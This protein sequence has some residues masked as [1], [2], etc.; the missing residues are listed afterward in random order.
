M[1]YISKQKNT[2]VNNERNVFTLY[3]IKKRTQL[4]KEIIKNDILLLRE[5]LKLIS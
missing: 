2:P 3:G 1:I 5:D 4:K